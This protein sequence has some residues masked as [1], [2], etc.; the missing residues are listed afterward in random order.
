MGCPDDNMIARLLS[1]EMAGELRRQLDEHVDDCE[2]C[3]ELVAAA[4]LHVAPT[5]HQTTMDT[6]LLDA[7]GNR[8]RPFHDGAMIDHFRVV[9]LLGQGGMG[10][11]YL[12]DDTR[13]GRK[14]ALKVVAT[15]LAGSPDASRRFLVE[16]QATARVAHPNIVAI[17]AVGEHADRPYVALEYVDGE[18]LQQ[19]LCDRRVPLQEWIR[20]AKSTAEA[21]SEAHRN[22]VTH[23]DLK[24]SNIIIGNDGRTRV[25]DFGL[26]KIAD[27]EGTGW[28]RED[29][30]NS[31]AGGTPSHMAPEQWAGGSVGPPADIWALGVILFE[32]CVGQRP[33]NP[34]DDAG[35]AARLLM[36]REEVCSSEP[37]PTV[38]GS[39]SRE[40][41]V[42]VARCL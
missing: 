15:R 22:G 18:T 11:V 42:L 12:A 19:R 39:V 2:S 24:P 41:A 4:A 10:E 1:R 8:A 28:A 23:R 32:M 25:V 20:I 21:L 5:E 7:S 35:K 40:L 33:F 16:A 36:Y 17:H 13:L 14:V 31:S 9:H 37:A 30:S 3:R 38:D 6:T 34:P 29:E 27:E 26:A